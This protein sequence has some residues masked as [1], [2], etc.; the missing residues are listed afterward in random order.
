[1]LALHLQHLAEQLK[2]KAEVEKTCNIL[3]TGL[4]PPMADLLV[5]APLEGLQHSLA[6]YRPVVT[7]GQSTVETLEATVQDAK[8]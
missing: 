4:T 7:M 8:R 3:S 5:K 6:I 2:S 1:M